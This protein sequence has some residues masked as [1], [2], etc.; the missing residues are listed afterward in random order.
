MTDWAIGRSNFP[1]FLLLQA[2]E[3]SPSI[4]PDQPGVVKA[5]V[6]PDRRRM[7]EVGKTPSESTIALAPNAPGLLF[8][9]AARFGQVMLPDATVP[10]RG[11]QFHLND[12]ARGRARLIRIRTSLLNAG[13][14][15]EAPEA[16]EASRETACTPVFWVYGRSA[17]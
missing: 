6:D 14:E 3:R 10:R 11:A 5:A 8:G 16:A 4:A 7:W 9:M 17:G 13:K 12:L 15:Y 2:S 1:G